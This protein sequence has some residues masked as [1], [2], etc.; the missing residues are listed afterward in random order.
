VAGSLPP[1]PRLP[2]ACVAWVRSL[3][4]DPPRW[5]SI[6]GAPA[7]PRGLF[8]FES[9]VPGLW[10]HC[11]RPVAAV[12]RSQANDPRH[13]P[14]NIPLRCQRYL[15]AHGLREL[16][17]T[18]R[19]GLPRMDDAALWA[20]AWETALWPAGTVET[21]YRSNREHAIETVLEADPVATALLAMMRGGIV[22]TVRPVRTMISNDLRRVVSLHGV[23]GNRQRSSWRSRFRQ[24]TP[25]PGLAPS[26]RTHADTHSLILT[27]SSISA[28]PF[29][30][31]ALRSILI[32]PPLGTLADG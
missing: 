12:D 3:C 10:T 24:N 8:A 20:R 16:P 5:N 27:I 25:P 23:E 30:I 18:S 21:V 13:V 29:W 9:D 1:R 4:I 22:R 2:C 7:S 6:T 26:P 14:W 31:R 17:G 28:S 19:Q 32:W 11:R 15:A